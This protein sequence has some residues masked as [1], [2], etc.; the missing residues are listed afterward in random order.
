M[1]SFKSM[2]RTVCPRD[3]KHVTVHVENKP[4]KRIVFNLQF[5]VNPEEIVITLI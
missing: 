2:I 5:K 4:I 1:L 3:W